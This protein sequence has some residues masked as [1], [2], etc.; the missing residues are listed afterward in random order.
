MVKLRAVKDSE[1]PLSL[2]TTP[3]PIFGQGPMP[4]TVHPLF[5]YSEMILGDERERE[6]A[7]MLL[8]LYGL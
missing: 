1:G 5:V 3:G 7:N 6:A 4:R 8:D 2:L